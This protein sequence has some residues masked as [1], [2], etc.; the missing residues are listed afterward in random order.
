[1]SVTE[2]GPKPAAPAAQKGSGN[3]LHGRSAVQRQ[4]RISWT[5]GQGNNI[6]QASA[7]DISKFGMLVEA[8]RPIRSGTLV[9]VQTNSAIIGKACVRHCTPKGAKFRIGLHLP[10]RMLREI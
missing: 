1:M 5:D 6:L 7:V 8:E 3:R 4:V 2:S 9:S 10:D